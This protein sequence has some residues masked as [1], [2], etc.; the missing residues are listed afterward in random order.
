M[1]QELAQNSSAA[2][3]KRKSTAGKADLAEMTLAAGIENA[4]TVRDLEGFR[5]EMTAGLSQNRLSFVVRKIE[6]SKD[7]RHIRRTDMDPLENKFL[8]IRYFERTEGKR[9]IRSHG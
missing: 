2:C 7:H 4:A 1:E 6:E 9:F 3:I 8:F 5:Q